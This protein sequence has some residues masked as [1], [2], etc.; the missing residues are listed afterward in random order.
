MEIDLEQLEVDDVTSPHPLKGDDKYTIY[1]ALKVALLTMVF[2]LGWM[3]LFPLEAPSYN[4]HTD[5]K[6]TPGEIIEREKDESLTQEDV[7]TYIQETVE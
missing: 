1:F 3:F 2:A 5:T 6:D 7:D 4:D